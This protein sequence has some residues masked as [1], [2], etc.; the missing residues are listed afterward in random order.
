M[1]TTITRHGA[2]FV[3]QT[4]DGRGC[5]SGC[6]EA[7]RMAQ[8]LKGARNVHGVNLTSCYG[9]NGGAFSNAQM[10]A[11]ATGLPVKGYYGTTNLAGVS[12]HGGKPVPFK[13]F[14]PQGP[15]TA[16]VCATGN[17]LLSGVVQAGIQLRNALTG[18]AG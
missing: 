6:K 8:T 15:V 7:S 11:N 14:R 10:L 4:A 12:R 5:A 1:Y 13:T 18:R 9:A 3:M 2:P 16:A 17:Q